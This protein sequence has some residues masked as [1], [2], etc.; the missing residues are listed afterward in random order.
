MEKAFALKDVQVAVRAA[1]SSAQTAKD[2]GDASKAVAARS[3]AAIAVAVN[4]SAG[5]GRKVYGSVVSDEREALKGAGV[6]VPG[7]RVSEALAVFYGPKGRAPHPEAAVIAAEWAGG[8]F[9]AH[10]LSDALKAVRATV[11]PAD[12]LA[13][14]VRKA[15]REGVTVDVVN[16][17][18]LA[19][20]EAG[21]QPAEDDD[22]E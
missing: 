11:T 22:A 8:D 3:Q 4:F 9:E 6:T 16:A 12:V 1:L 14:A 2:H 10:T 21:V 18:V 13:K 17:V 20:L 7:S 5:L 15:L 19:A